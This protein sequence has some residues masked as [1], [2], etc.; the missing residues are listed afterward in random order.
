MS[1]IVDFGQGSRAGHPQI[2][3]K[4]DDYSACFPGTSANTETIVVSSGRQEYGNLL[5]HFQKSQYWDVTLTREGV[6]RTEVAACNYGVPARVISKL[7]ME[8]R[9]QTEYF[10]ALSPIQ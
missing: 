1:R 2:R 7:G 5:R 4:G 9:K 3:R 10:T 8:G 6:V